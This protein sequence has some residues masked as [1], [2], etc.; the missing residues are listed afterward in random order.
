MPDEVKPSRML[1]RLEAEITSAATPQQADCKRAER[2]AYLSRLG[3]FEEARDVVNELRQRYNN[4]PQV[5]VSAWINLAE[6]LTEY[7]RN[8]G[9]SGTDRVQRAYAL[10]RAAGLQ[11]MR[12][13]CAAWLAQW[14]YAL[15]DM[16]S[17]SH[18]VVEALQFAH[19]QQHAALSRV[20]LVVAQ[21][22]HLAGRSDLAQVWYRKSREHAT[23]DHDDVT[24]SA[25]MHNMAWLRMFELRQAVLSGIGGVHPGRVALISAESNAHFDQMVGDSSW[26]SLKPILR[27]QILSLQ[28]DAAD[29]LKLYEGH[30]AGTKSAV[31]LQANLWAD[32]AWCYAHLNRFVEAR[33][34]ADIAQRSLCEETQID[35]RAAAHSRLAQVFAAIGEE[36]EHSKHIQHALNAWLAYTLLQ[37]K[38]IELLGDLHLTI[39][40]QK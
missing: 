10:S 39:L 14:D 36:S 17:L 9:V 28:G 18:H 1:L 27:A 13:L 33:D 30:L 24:I 26:Q 15:L 31:R 7:F 22:L 8:V 32:K 29:A 19:P 38:I 25:L 20:S 16:D 34:C 11:Q 12:A 21:A 37:T 35:D 6:G 2:A 4:H 40:K 5:E 3:R 23:A